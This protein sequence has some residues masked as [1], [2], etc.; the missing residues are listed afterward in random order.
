MSLFLSLHT[1]AWGWSQWN[2]E[3]VLYKWNLSF[4]TM[5]VF[6]DG[7]WWMMSTG[8]GQIRKPDATVQLGTKSRS[9]HSYSLT[10]NGKFSMRWLSPRKPLCCLPLP[11]KQHNIW[12]T[13]ID[14]MWG[15]FVSHTVMQTSASVQAHIK[16]D[17]KCCQRSL[18]ISE[19][20]TR[21]VYFM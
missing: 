13:Y 7:D 12:V 3:H 8:R 15:V 16:S 2:S 5:E 4:E 1:P 14:R 9:C 11:A 18:L 19:F 10:R 17:N 20:P 6:T 21:L